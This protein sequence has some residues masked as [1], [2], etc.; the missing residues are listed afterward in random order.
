MRPENSR[1]RLR[2]T[3]S[4]I[5][6]KPFQNFIDGL[7]AIREWIPVLLVT[8]VETYLKDVL[9]YAASLDPAITESSEQPMPSAS[10]TEV[11]R[12]G[13]FEALAQELRSEWARNFVDNKGGPTRWIKRLHSMGARGYHPETAKKMETL[14]GVRHLIVH[15]SGLATPDF[16]RLHPEIG[17]KVGENI[18]IRPNQII[19]WSKVVYDF[20]DVTDSYFVQRYRLG[21]PSTT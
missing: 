1:R 12:A 14:W 10:Y 17:V 20:V 2:G 21:T 5:L 8:T 9:I 3:R 11:V 16:V 7:L 6:G 18:I 4:D 19:A 13:S 15:S